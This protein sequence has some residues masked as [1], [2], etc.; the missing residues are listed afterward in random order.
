MWYYLFPD[1]KLTKEMPFYIQSIG[2][3]E[4]Q[5]TIVRPLGHPYNQI[6]YSS[7]G[8]GI[9][10]IKNKRYELPE[11]SA[12]FIPAN[13]PHEYYPTGEIWDI[14]WLAITGDQ[15]SSILS[16]LNYKAGAYLDIN[17][18]SLDLIFNKMHHLLVLNESLGNVYASA[19]LQEFLTAFAEECGFIPHIHSVKS[20]HQ[21]YISTIV[22]YVAYH[23]MHD[24][25]NAELC[26]I[27]GIS[28]QHL[29]RIVK[30]A[31]NMTVVEYINYIRIK[32]SKELLINSDLCIEDIA[33]A[34]GFKNN[35][36]FWRTFKKYE[37]ITPGDY[38]KHKLK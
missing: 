25:S 2:L 31:T 28:S 32:K 12:F 9:L 20:A 17:V 14:R 4:F 18:N 8:T 11:K 26:E 6:F 27:T 16:A 19:H 22:D 15:A 7:S 23:F 33:R 21:A 34:C 35:N 1:T 38:R 36:Y 30:E 37:G 29:C 3:H 5:G 13:V 24:I 10:K